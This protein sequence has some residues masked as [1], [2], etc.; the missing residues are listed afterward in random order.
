M[1][2]ESQGQMQNQNDDNWK[3]PDATPFD[4]QHHPISAYDNQAESQPNQDVTPTVDVE[5]HVIEQSSGYKADAAPANNAAASEDEV[6]RWTAP[7]Y[8]HRDQQPMWYMILA[9]ITVVLI[10]LAIFVMKSYT[11]ALLIPVMAAALVVYTRRPPIEFQY[12]LGRK[13][14]HVNDVLHT[15]DEYRAFS[16]VLHHDHN[17]ITMI[18]R[19]RFSLGE[20]IHFPDELGEP[21]VDLLA[22]RLPMKER[23]PDLFDRIIS[24]LG[25]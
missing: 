20:T 16:V 18:P 14:L 24:R 1:N 22:A 13:G 15:Y 11:F 17:T 23:S 12:I 2:P 9:F 7:A 5:G 3:Q 6:I 25:L 21:I 8:I 10:I 4:G 19:K